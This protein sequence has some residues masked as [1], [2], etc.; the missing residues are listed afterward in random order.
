MLLRVLTIAAFATVGVY[1]QYRGGGCPEQ[2][3]VQVYPHEGACDR[4]YKVGAHSIN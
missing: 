4:F 3:G 2:Y 1:G